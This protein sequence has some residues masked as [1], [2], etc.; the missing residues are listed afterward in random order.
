M[1]KINYPL[2]SY[3][4]Y[5][6]NLPRK[7]RD[8]TMYVILCIILFTTIFTSFRMHLTRNLIIVLKYLLNKNPYYF[9]SN[10]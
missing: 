2:V 6:K 8:F 1:H 4:Y 10:Y 3:K 7:I 5:T 9:L